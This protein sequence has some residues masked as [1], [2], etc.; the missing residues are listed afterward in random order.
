MKIITDF[1]IHAL[2]E[3]INESLDKNEVKRLKSEVEEEPTEK[4][5]PENL[6]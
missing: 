1:K 3:S 4:R 2:T 6:R 5:K